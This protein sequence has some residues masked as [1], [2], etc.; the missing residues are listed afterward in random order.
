M[1]HLNIFDYSEL[2]AP[3]SSEGVGTFSGLLRVTKQVLPLVCFPS[4]MDSEPFR[5]H[6]GDAQVTRF[7]EAFRQSS[8]VFGQ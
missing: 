4:Q 1:N 5:G 8:V 7:S 6:Y 2:I 3:D